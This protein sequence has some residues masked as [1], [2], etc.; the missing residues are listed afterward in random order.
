MRGPY[1]G[2]SKREWEIEI[3]IERERERDVGFYWASRKSSPIMIEIC[4]SLI[5]DK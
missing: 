4:T 2:L 1:R 3:E 5:R